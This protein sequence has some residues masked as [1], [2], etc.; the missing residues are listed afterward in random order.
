VQ[1]YLLPF[2]LNNS[3]HYHNLFLFKF[4][5]EPHFCLMELALAGLDPSLV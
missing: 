2:E 4:H 3:K 5:A 1:L